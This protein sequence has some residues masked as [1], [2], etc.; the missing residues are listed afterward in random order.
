[1]KPQ[2]SDNS[3]GPAMVRDIAAEF[4]L[5]DLSLDGIVRKAG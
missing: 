5:L 4:P 1:M 3:T 2:G